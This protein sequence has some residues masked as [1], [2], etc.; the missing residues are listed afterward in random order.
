[1]ARAETGIANG[2]Q[3]LLR[4]AVIELLENALRH[5]RPQGNIRVSACLTNGYANV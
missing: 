4:E 3:V 2:N 1:M 5:S